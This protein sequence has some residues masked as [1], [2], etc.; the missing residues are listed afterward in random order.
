M[1]IIQSLAGA[2]LTLAL[3][4]SGMTH[5]ESNS[6]M[7]QLKA[8]EGDWL[9]VDEQGEV[10]DDVASQF[11][12]TSNES[13]LR[14]VMAPG[15][16]HEMLNVYH[17]DGDRVLMTHYCAARNQPRLE[18]VRAQEGNS[19]L[20]RFESITNLSSPDGHYMGRARYDWDG[21]DRVTT[22]W[23]STA[24]G[25]ESSEEPMVIRLAR[26]RD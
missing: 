8:L 1:N 5:A 2:G 25:E 15:T 17:T 4:V 20:L 18:V 13:V 23:Y 21:D 14:E 11:R 22:T 6:I 19:L 16:E 10:T 12:I 9:L 3:T 26:R 7:Q 24:N